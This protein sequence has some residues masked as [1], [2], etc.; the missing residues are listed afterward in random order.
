MQ[1]MRLMYWLG[2]L[3]ALLRNLTACR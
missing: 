2:G 1:A 3:Y